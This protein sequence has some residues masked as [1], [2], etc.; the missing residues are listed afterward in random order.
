VYNE[1]N[2]PFYEANAEAAAEA[3]AEL[4]EDDAAES[5]MMYSINGYIFCNL[6]GLN[7]TTGERWAHGCCAR[8]F[9]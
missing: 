5:N 4:S 1:A 6:P 2:S 3:L 8:H 9:N 7:M